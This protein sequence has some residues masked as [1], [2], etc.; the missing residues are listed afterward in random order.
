MKKTT[1][2]ALEAFARS[3]CAASFSVMIN[4]SACHSPVRV[5]TPELGDA[6]IASMVFMLL[7]SRL[8]DA[9]KAAQTFILCSSPPNWPQFCDVRAY[10]RTL[11][12]RL[13]TLLHRFAV[14]FSAL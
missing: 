6:V 9:F 7:L 1:G 10:S 13:S 2:V 5:S 14:V 8:T 3:T 12:A 11:A 4:T